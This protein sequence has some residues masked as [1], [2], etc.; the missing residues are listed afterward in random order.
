MATPAPGK[1]LPSHLET[2]TSEETMRILFVEDEPDYFKLMKKQLIQWGCTVDAV[3]FPID[4]LSLLNEYDY[5]IFISDYA[6]PKGH[7]DG[8]S[9]INTYRLRLGKALPI[10]LTAYSNTVK[11]KIP[12][13]DEIVVIDKTEY[14]QLEEHLIDV[15]SQVLEEI[16]KNKQSFNQKYSYRFPLAEAELTH[17]QEELIATLVNSPDLY[18]KEIAYGD[19]TYSIADL[20]EEIKRGDESKL[21]L[22]LIIA[23]RELKNVS[24][25]EEGE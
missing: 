22:D 23:M 3:T 18:L 15:H 20:I 13:D 25:D 8:L 7:L 4:A 9:F 17:I 21:G 1:I 10:I 11:K 14:W 24:E 16:S 12:E 2:F 6:F 5:Q 19:K